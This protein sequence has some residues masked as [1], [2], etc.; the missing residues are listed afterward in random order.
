MASRT[1]VLSKDEIEQLHKQLEGDIKDEKKPPYTY[2]Q[3]KADGITYTAYTSGKVLAQGK[4]ISIASKRI[5]AKAISE[6][7]NNKT[8]NLYPQIGSDEVGCGDYFGPIVVGIC[9]IESQ[10]IADMLLAE[11]V[12]DSKKLSD[13][14]VMELSKTIHRLTRCRTIVL[15]P[16]KYNEWVR[17]GLNMVDIKCIL[18]E[19]AWS[20]MDREVVMPS[21]KY[22][23]GFCDAKR[24][25][26]ALKREPIVKGIQYRP[27]A[28]S[29]YVSVMCGA[30]IA[31]AKFLHYTGQM[32]EDWD[33]IFPKGASDKVDNAGVKFLMEHDLM[34]LREVAK[35]SF[36]NTN[37]IKKMY[38][39][40]KN[41]TGFQE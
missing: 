31:R 30:I 20:D 25:E 19:K 24:Y 3:I 12:K 10:R 1:W 36:A 26:T 39:V 6:F 34:D 33:C 17:K 2:W 13:K 23:D 8:V 5:G 4:D 38:Y 11:G 41:Y 21:N 7:K 40:T 15:S 16:E 27:K 18:H 35:E 22:I 9:Y 28:D 32:E 14:K 29:M 37:K